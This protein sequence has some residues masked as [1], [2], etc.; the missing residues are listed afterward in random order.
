MRQNLSVP[1][2]RKVDWLQK[3]EQ[4]IMCLVR[5]TEDHRVQYTED[6]KKGEGVQ[7]TF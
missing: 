3:A 5:T 6:R 4:W 1:V 7:V 2:H